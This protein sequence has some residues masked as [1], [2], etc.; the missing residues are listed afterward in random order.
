M[1][2][3][4]LVQTFF[5]TD[6]RCIDTKYSEETV[7]SRAV[8]LAKLGYCSVEKKTSV[9]H[10]FQNN[11]LRFDMHKIVRYRSKKIVRSVQLLVTGFLTVCVL[12]SCLLLAP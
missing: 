6:I 10:D 5:R 4:I 9:K 2:Y 8:H 12:S 11:F 3:W 1:R 7:S